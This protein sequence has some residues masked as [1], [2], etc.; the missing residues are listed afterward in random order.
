[1]LVDVALI[2]LFGGFY[3]VPLYALIQ[4]RSDRS[5]QSRIIAGNNILNA[6]FIVAAAL[7][8]AGFLALG[9]T[10]PQLFLL[11]ALL[12]A[13]VAAFIYAQVPEFLMR[14]LAWLLVHSVY[15][16][17]KSGLENI[18]EEGPAVLV[19]NHVSFVDAV[20]IMAACR[21][22]IRFVMDH[23]I[24]RIPVLSF[25]FRTGGAIPIA[26]R[27]DDPEMME[28]AF[29]EVARALAAA[30][31]VGIFPEGRITDTGEML[32]VPPR[33][34]ADRRGDAGAG[35]AARSARAVGQLLQPQG[36][37]GDDEAVPP[38]AVR[39]DRARRSAGRPAGAGHR[40]GAAG[41]GA[42]VA[43][44]LALTSRLGKER[45]PWPFSS[46]P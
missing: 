17:E 32:P 44:R 9:A 21:R 24:F 29:D 25:I 45:E 31:L 26:P 12:N 4:S 30:E 8:G 19:C 35:G 41:R 39:E 15:R 20:V 3:I 37:C 7:V 14:F 43:R 46:A 42:G 2:G 13:A 38:R 11:T 23:A 16:V 1:M 34:P 40:R 5:H 33:H 10:V 18:P 28:R 6:L 22:P 27:K 36:R